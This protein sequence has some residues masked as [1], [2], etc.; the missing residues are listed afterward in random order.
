MSTP[1]TINVPDDLIPEL[2]RVAAREFRTAEGQ[3]LWFLR[4]GLEKVTARAQPPARRSLP[5]RAARFQPVLQE[6]RRL[7][8]NQGKP[9]GRSLADVIRARNSRSPIAHTTV[10]TILAGTAVPSWPALEQIVIALHGDV[11][12][13]KEL[14]MKAAGEAG[15]SATWQIGSRHA[16]YRTVLPGGSVTPLVI[17]HLA[18]P[19]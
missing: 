11:P 17:L 12:R 15:L 8:L 19:C 6:L 14:W 10:S 1:L 3:V 4:Q 13:F 18:N 16:G 5:D 9:S 7:H 2:Q